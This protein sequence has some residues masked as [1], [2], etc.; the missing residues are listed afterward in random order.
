MEDCPYEGED[1]LMA[2]DTIYKI[3][4]E[5]I[6]FSSNVGFIWGA[7]TAK[8]LIWCLFGMAK[9]YLDDYPMTLRE[10]EQGGKPC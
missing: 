6:Y 10:Y 8:P 1:G 4:G 7:A 3:D 2:G 5:R 9:I